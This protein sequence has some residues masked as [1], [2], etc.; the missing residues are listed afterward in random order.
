MNFLVCACCR[1]LGEAVRPL[2]E[3]PER[4]AVADPDGPGTPVPTG[5]SR[6][7]PD[8]VRRVPA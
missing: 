5:R 2:P 4:P 1:R 6:F 3:S 7:L 8:A